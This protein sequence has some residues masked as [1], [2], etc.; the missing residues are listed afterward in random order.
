MIKNIID[1][2]VPEKFKRSDVYE[3]IK[4]TG[5]LC[6]VE[7]KILI[8]DYNDTWPIVTEGEAKL[9]IRT[10]FKYKEWQSVLDDKML[11]SIIKSFKT[12]PDLQRSLKDFRH[13]EL[14]KVNNGIWNISK[15]EI[16]EV[17]NQ[18]FNRALDVTLTKELPKE[19]EV[20]ISFCN[21]VF[22]EDTVN[23]KKQV[24][25]EMIGYCVSETPPTKVANFLIGPANCGKSVMLKFIQE[26]IG[27]KHVSNVPLSA[28]AKEFNVSEM[29]EKV[30]NITGEVPSGPIPGGALD[31]FKGITGGDR[32]QINKKYGDP[33]SQTLDLKLLV[34]GNSLPIFKKV[35]GTDSLV[36]RLHILVFDNV[37]DEQKRDFQL[38]DKLW[39]ERDV[40]V[41]YALKAVKEYEERGRYF[42]K[43]ED[44]MNMLQSLRQVANPIAHFMKEKIHKSET[45]EVHISDVYE[46]YQKF[47]LAEALPDLDRTTFRNL[48]TSQSGVRIGKTK[49]RLGKKSPQVCFAGIEL[50]NMY[51]N[52]QE[53][54]M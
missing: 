35:D 44:E 31:I 28:F 49:K 4:D 23:E 16:V 45:S 43:L 24:L 9:L 15:G 33:T 48:M 21:K 41:R 38:I 10:M 17:N 46:A 11:A 53:T 50:K 5:E 18:A 47:A 13:E 22:S 40:I 37:V 34:A 14:I 1:V 30:I 39:D 27:E 42:L 51:D 2:P 20:F 52:D 19:S 25:Y 54:E 32:M 8:H 26:I 12:D 29:S 7:G 3:L 36:E 6:V